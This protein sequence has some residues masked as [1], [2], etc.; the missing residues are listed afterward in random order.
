MHLY[1]DIDSIID[2]LNDEL[3]DQRAREKWSAQIAAKRASQLQRQT[4]ARCLPDSSLEFS[5]SCY[6]FGLAGGNI[7]ALNVSANTQSQGLQE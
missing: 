7:G 6:A 5:D 2:D 3:A 1:R 4:S